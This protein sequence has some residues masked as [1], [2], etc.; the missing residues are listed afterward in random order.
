MRRVLIWLVLASL[1]LAGCGTDHGDEPGKPTTA[2]YWCPGS[3]EGSEPIEGTATRASDGTWS[4]RRDTLPDE[5]PTSTPKATKVGK[6]LQGNLRAN[7]CHVV[8]KSNP[9]AGSSSSCPPEGTRQPA[10]MPNLVGMEYAKGQA[11]LNARLC[12][13]GD[14]VSVQ[15][16]TRHTCKTQPGTY[17]DQSPQPGSVLV[18]NTAVHVYVEAGPPCKK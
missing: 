9:A 1:A 17:V 4:I 15:A 2:R 5:P 18:P 3:G 11:L 12:A 16:R 14:N 7:G 13:A 10:T 6:D 8:T